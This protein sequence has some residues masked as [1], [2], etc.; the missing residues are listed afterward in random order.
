MTYNDF[1][2]ST[3]R[4]VGRV[5]GE[6]VIEKINGWKAQFA[7]LIYNFIHLGEHAFL[8]GRPSLSSMNF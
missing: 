2:A 5:E 8:H 1:P 4:V 3:L 7:I 6:M